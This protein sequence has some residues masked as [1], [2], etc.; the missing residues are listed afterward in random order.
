MTEV[1]EWVEVEGAQHNWVN[2]LWYELLGSKWG[3][4][5]KQETEWKEWRLEE[6]RKSSIVLV[7]CLQGTAN[8][9]SSLCGMKN[10]K[11]DFLFCFGFFSHISQWA[12]W[13]KSVRPS[14]GLSV[15]VCRLQA[16]TAVDNGSHC[17]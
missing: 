13:C 3:D 4:K 11:R 12:D 17:S 8:Y 1:E 14:V 9:N 10:S 16:R 15:C 7:S 5:L 6:K 2:D